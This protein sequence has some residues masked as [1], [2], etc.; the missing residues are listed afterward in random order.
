MHYTKVIASLAALVSASIAQEFPDPACPS[1]RNELRDAAPTPPPSLS[2]FLSTEAG[3][4]QSQGAPNADIL[5]TNPDIYVDQVC[6]LVA[7]LPSSVLGDF[8]SWGASLLNFASVE[9]SSYDAIVTK[10]ITTGAAAAS[11]TSYIHSIAS[12]PEALC[13]PT[14]TA[15]GG[16]GTASITPYPTPTGNST[17]PGTG[18]SSTLIPTAAAAVGRTGDSVHA[19]VMGG[20][21][22]GI[23]LL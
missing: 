5:L 22:A 21:V 8:Q 16:N 3:Q 11:I 17:I 13:Q 4:N 12:S 7:S 6:N 2:P 23:A 9:I 19:A 20:L 18:I 15:G 10:C 1:S 14:S